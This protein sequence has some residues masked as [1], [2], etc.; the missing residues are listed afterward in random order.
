[1]P[2]L[3]RPEQQKSE[4]RHRMLYDEEKDYMMRM[5]REISR[6]LFSI[7]FGKKYTQVELEIRNKYETAGTPQNALKD[8]IDRGKI[9][10]AENILLEDIDY[11]RKEDVAAAVAFYQYLGE[12]PDSFLRQ[13][14][15]SRQEVLDG[16]N[17]LVECS[18]Y[19]QIVDMMVDRKQE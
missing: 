3:C 1:M 13:H 10:E 4:K 6:V 16:L 14:G 2:A 19:A 11:S 15:F 7:L 18:G 9:D 17:N 12:K 8:L 5:I